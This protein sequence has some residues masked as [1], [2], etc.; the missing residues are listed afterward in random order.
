MM[1][2]KHYLVSMRDEKAAPSERALDRYYQSHLLRRLTTQPAYRGVL[3]AVHPGL[4]SVAGRVSALYPALEWPTQRTRTDAVDRSADGPAE[5]QDRQPRRHSCCASR[6]RGATS[7]SLAW[8]PEIACKTSK[9]AS[10]E[11]SSRPGG[12]YQCRGSLSHGRV[13]TDIRVYC[14]ASKR[15][16]RRRTSTF[17]ILKGSSEGIELGRVMRLTRSISRFLGEV[18]RTSVEHPPDYTHQR[19]PTSIPL[20]RTTTDTPRLRSLLNRRP[21]YPETY[22]TFPSSCSTTTASGTSKSASSRCSRS[23]TLQKSWS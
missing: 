16:R 17:F 15:C 23:I 6:W 2:A 3:V 8:R 9:Q 21:A 14:A 20:R 13:R 18:Q 5:P 4:E 12:E 1:V 19:R 22:L 11:S 7:I 10:N